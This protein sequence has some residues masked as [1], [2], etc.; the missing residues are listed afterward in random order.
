MA[1]V[2]IG[3]MVEI[4]TT[5]GF[6]YAHYT[7]KHKQYGALLRVF[8]G[9]Y[10]APPSNLEDV[11]RQKVAFSCFFPLGAAVHRKI[12]SVVGNVAVPDEAQKF[13]TFRTGIV[14]P[15]TRKVDVWWLWD[16][17]REW[18]VGNLTP[19]QR[20]FPIRGTWNDT[21]LI[22]RIESHWTPEKDPT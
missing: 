8:Q 5:R 1:R 18:R 6:A 3:D 7:H 10:D 17:E 16:G 15:S 22:E 4:K 13:P 2:K 20:T 21:L 12:V 14:N 19:E 9:L 11:V